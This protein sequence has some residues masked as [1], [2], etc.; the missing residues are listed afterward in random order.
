MSDLVGNT[1][2]W[3]SRE[4]AQLHVLKL[5]EWIKSPTMQRIGIQNT[6]RLGNTR[7]PVRRKQSPYWTL[8]LRGRLGYGR[9]GDG[10]L[11]LLLHS[12]WLRQTSD[13]SAKTWLS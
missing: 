1:D 10:Q 13:I 11:I 3:F 9:Y 5:F 4:K 12:D 8:S 2:C 7:E 6:R